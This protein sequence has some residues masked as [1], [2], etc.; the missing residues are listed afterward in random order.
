MR[1]C[2]SGRRGAIVLEEEVVVVAAVAVAVAVAIASLLSLLVIIL[3][4]QDH[5]SEAACL[6]GHDYI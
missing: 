1:M 2:I 5:A 6:T 3:H 4:P